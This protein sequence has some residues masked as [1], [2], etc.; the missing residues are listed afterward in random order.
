MFMCQM[1]KALVILTNVILGRSCD[2][3]CPTNKCQGTMKIVFDGR[4]KPHWQCV[5]CKVII[6]K[7]DNTISRTLDTRRIER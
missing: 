7:G 2:M 3:R 6:P 5:R 1:M 4:A